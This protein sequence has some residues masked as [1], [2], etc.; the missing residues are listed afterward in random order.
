MLAG[1]I[2]WSNVSGANLSQL[3]E[4]SSQTVRPRLSRGEPFLL[5][6]DDIGGRPG[7]EL[8]VRELA[9]EALDLALGL[10]QLLRQFRALG[11]A[12]DQAGQGDDDQRLRE[13]RRGDAFLGR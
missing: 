1:R 4:A 10:G 6:G 11:V 12:V 8:L 9:F 13:D 3:H 7:A 5:F 2:T